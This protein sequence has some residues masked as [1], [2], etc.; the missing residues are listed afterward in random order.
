MQNPELPQTPPRNDNDLH[1]PPPVIRIRRTPEI[2]VYVNRIRYLNDVNRNLFDQSNRQIVS[3][4][5]Q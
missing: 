1:Y 5:K 2:G 4:M 3:T